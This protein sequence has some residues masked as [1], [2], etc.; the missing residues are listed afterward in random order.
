MLHEKF[1]HMTQIITRNQIQA[2]GMSKYQSQ[3]ITKGL[4]SLGKKG[5]AY[6]YDLNDVILAIRQYIQRSRIKQY[7][8]ETLNSVLVT[9][10]TRLGN[11]VEIPF[12][13]GSDP[14]IRKLGIK[15]IQAMAKTDTSVANLKA[16]LAEINAK[17]G[18][19]Q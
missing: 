18:F 15:L 4:I 9:L 19:L 7:T 11:T 6:L 5:Q 17:Y 16:D 3:I 1:E 12:D 2:Y 8:R 10:L 13:E 14:R